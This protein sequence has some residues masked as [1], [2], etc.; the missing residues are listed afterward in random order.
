[1]YD[2]V[3]HSGA[4]HPNLWWIVVPSLLSLLVGIGIGAFSE[5]VRA[6]VGASGTQPAE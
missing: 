1:M 4:E 3:L 5:R 6:L 2:L